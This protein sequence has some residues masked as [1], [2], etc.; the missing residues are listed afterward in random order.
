MGEKIRVTIIVAFHFMRRRL[1]RQSDT[2]GC[3][4]IRKDQARKVLELLDISQQDNAPVHNLILEFTLY[5]F[6]LSNN[7][8]L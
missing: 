4:Q 8:I 6:Y 1:K 3:L 5:S 7:F 2:S